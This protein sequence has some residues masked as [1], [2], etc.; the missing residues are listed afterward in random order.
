[1]KGIK[2]G[3]CEKQYDDLL[4]EGAKRANYIYM[5]AALKMQMR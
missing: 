1:V 3:G 2:A 4:K 5:Q